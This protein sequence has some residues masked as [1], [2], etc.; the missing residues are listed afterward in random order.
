MG[1]DTRRRFRPGLPATLFTAF[2]LPLLLALGTWQL[3]RAGE[4]RALFADFAAGG[5]AVALSGQR[6]LYSVSRVGRLAGA[7]RDPHG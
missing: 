4:K 5:A 7:A 1:T 2:F 6:R 3:N